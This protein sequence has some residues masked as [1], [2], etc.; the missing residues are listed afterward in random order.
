MTQYFRLADKYLKILE[1]G[2][3]ACV[4][5]DNAFL[6]AKRAQNTRY[7]SKQNVAFLTV[8]WVCFTG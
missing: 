5:R 6:L 3:E 1:T 8:A 7:Y 4:S 2:L